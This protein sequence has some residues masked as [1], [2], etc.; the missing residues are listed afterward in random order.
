MSNQES[1]TNICRI[2]VEGRS[3]EFAVLKKVFSLKEI[4]TYG[5]IRL[6]SEGICAI[7]VNGNFVEA[8][9]GRLPNRMLYAEITSHLHVGENEIRLVSGAHY[10]QKTANEQFG[11]RQFHFSS[12]AA[13]VT[14]T[15]ES[16]TLRIPTDDTWD[17]ECEDAN[18]CFT[19]CGQITKAEYERFWLRAAL[20]RERSA[21]PA[22]PQAIKDVAGEAY[23]AYAASEEPTYAE[24]IV[25]LSDVLPS[26]MVGA[27]RPEMVKK[28]ER[29]AIF[30]FSRLVVGYTVLSYECEEDVP[31]TLLYDYTEITAD[32][33]ASK[34]VERL[35]I[36]TTLK[37]GSTE[38]QLVRRRAA[39]FVLVKYPATA[40]FRLKG[41]RMRLSMLPSAQKGWFRCEDE[42]LNR[43]WEVGKYT[44]Q[45]N[46][47]QEY[48]S[49]PRNEMKFFSGDGIMDALVD[50]YAYGDSGLTDASLS[51]TEP[52]I[53]VGLRPD[54]HDRNA[55]LWDYPA[56][57]M[58][59]Y[60]NHYLYT[61][62]RSFVEF[63][64][65]E[66]VQLIRWMIN[67]IG[68]DDL[69]YQHPV[70]FDVFFSHSDATEYSC[71][72]HRLGRKTYLNVL[73]YKSLLCMADFAD[74]M[75][76]KRAI[77]WRELAAR[78][79]AAINKVL[80]SEQFE[81]YYDQQQPDILPQEGN[82]LAVLFDV[83]DEM[84]GRKVFAALEKYNWSPY[85]SAMLSREVKH[86]RGGISSIS[87]LMC[88]YEAEARFLHGDEKGALELMRRCWGTML[89]KGA[90][91][92]W[93]FTYNNGSDRWP[94]PAHS[95]SAGCTYL[96]SA[97]VAG[98]RPAKEGYGKLLFAPVAELTEFEC[99]VPTPK[100]YVAASCRTKEGAL[101]YTL[102]L[103]KGMALETKLPAGATLEKQYY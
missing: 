94:I 95:W 17:Y 97:Y 102:A 27:D 37:K 69:V 89:A 8:H 90:E 61:G 29:Y 36:Q 63:Y 12:V 39:H 55:A 79:K 101:H 66:M 103:P 71:S 64:Y 19:V 10:D 35:Q 48:E 44:L 58:I 7:Y 91:T 74:L 60:H 26:T 11:A 4:S 78:M 83:A 92:F 22:V 21:D 23:A 80:W 82:A 9:K 98:I 99:V 5:T 45:V 6:T 96:L 70:Y 65:K 77:E 49:C 100:G 50:Y 41:L 40:K 43:M 76:D 87:P 31:V 68:S 72:E 93:E 18:A 32:F 86:T 14:V 81:A 24:P 34:M 30:D 52:Y 54:E 62:D 51:Y 16:G 47:H 42:L 20:W 73:F 38:L 3:C 84:Q 25:Y 57:R 88:T 46:K 85:G 1:L 13:E 75:Q 28:N 59:M 53:S 67:R 33:N 15:T 56:W 2:G